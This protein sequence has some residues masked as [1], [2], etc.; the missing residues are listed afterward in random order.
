MRNRNRFRGPYGMGAL[1][2]VFFVG[3]VLALFWPWFAIVLL[4]LAVAAA[5]LLLVKPMC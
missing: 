5:V 2:A 3:L 1:C 4:C